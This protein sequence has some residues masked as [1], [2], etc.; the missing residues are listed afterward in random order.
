[1]PLPLRWRQACPYYLATKIEAFHGRER[2]DF[3]GSQDME[4]LVA[5]VNGRDT[6]LEE[7]RR[8]HPALRR[9]LGHEFSRF[10]KDSR[11]QD[12]LDG[13]LG[14]EEPGQGRKATLM[15]RLREIAAHER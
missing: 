2:D 3:M 12:S 13:H 11:F 4:D 15:K 9:H 14:F 6:L 8:T 5:V 7:I 1:M 10:L